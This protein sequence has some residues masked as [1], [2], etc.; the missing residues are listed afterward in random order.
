LKKEK[1]KKVDE[2]KKKKEKEKLHRT[3]K[4]PE[5]DNNKKYD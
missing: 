2:R 5:V 3:V 4:S 1:R